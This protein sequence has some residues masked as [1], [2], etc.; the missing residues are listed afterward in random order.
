[1]VARRNWRSGHRTIRTGPR[2]ANAA[3]AVLRRTV[4]TE[5][6]EKQ[7][8]DADA[9]PLH[10]PLSLECGV[11]LKLI[12]LGADRLEYLFTRCEQPLHVTFDWFDERIRV[13]D[14]HV[15]VQVREI[16]TCIALD[17]VQLLRVR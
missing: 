2:T 17:D 6:H 3:G 15:D 11:F 13:D 10:G 1:M 14:G 12:V 8:Y 9:D 7:R 4:R 5:H 16:R